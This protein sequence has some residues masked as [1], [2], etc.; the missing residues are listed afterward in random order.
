MLEYFS[1]AY[2]VPSCVIG[3]FFEMKDYLDFI[4][5]RNDYAHK[6][7]I[8]KYPIV[9]NKFLLGI[10][11]AILLV[12]FSKVSNIDIILDVNNEYSTMRKVN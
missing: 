7:K 11:F 1:Y 3:P 4:H 2:F 5:K 12:I 6:D 10:L 9:L 8:N